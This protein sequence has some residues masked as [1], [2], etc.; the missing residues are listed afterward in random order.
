MLVCT[1]DLLFRKKFARPLRF[2]DAS[3]RNVSQTC[4]DRTMPMFVSMPPDNIRIFTK[5]FDMFVVLNE[6]MLSRRC[7][8]ETYAPTIKIGLNERVYDI[9]LI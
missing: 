4:I 9:H 2:N 1:C 7:A 8:R 3:V 5:L 6:M